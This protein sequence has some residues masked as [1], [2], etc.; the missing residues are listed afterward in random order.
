[1][2]KIKLA[3]VDD[4]AFIRKA[5][6][7]LMESDQRIQVVGLA[8]S[9]EDLLANL[10]KWNPDVITLDLVMP[11]MGGLYTLDRIMEWKSI[12]VIILSTY[13]TKDAPLT[14]EALHRGAVDFIDKKQYSL[15]DFSG[16]RTILIEKILQVT[17]SVFRKSIGEDLSL[18]EPRKK[19]EPPAASS[20]GKMQFEAILIGASTGGP[21]TLQKI[22]ED[23]E[24]VSLSVAIVQHMPIGFTKA[25]ADR[26]NSHLQSLVKEAEHG[27]PF[28]PGYIYIAPSG[29]HLVL[30]RLNSKVYTHLTKYP[31]N[32]LHRPS[33]DVLFKSAVQTYG[34]QTLAVLLTGMGKDGAQGMSELAKSGAYTLAQDEASSVVYGM[35]KAAVELDAVS[36]VLNLKK[37]GKRIL[38]LI[39]HKQV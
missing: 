36:E 39:N 16:L 20:I 26:L 25:F 18:K 9:G 28:V 30:K 15:V 33:V 5:I 24:P 29:T 34:K 22:L 32:V 19:I 3:I 1:M 13:S 31:D 23:I 10:G 27:E 38:E 4:S 21:P 6:K 2:R 37:I 11:G 8:E 35:P 17:S 14:I 7:R 12:P